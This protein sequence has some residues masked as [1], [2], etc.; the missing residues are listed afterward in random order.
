MTPGTWGVA[1]SGVGAA[2]VP[3]GAEA[4]GRAGGK[5]HRLRVSCH[6]L[7]DKVESPQSFP[8]SSSNVVFCLHFKCSAT[9]PLVRPWLMF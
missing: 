6:L 3:K 5:R 8:F 4:V 1:R 7:R 2:A 9:P